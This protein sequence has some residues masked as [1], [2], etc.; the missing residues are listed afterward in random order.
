MA[1]GTYW[2]GV[3]GEVRF[4]PDETGVEITVNN[5]EWSK[6]RSN[7]LAEVTNAQS[8]GNSKYIASVNDQDGTFT[9]VWDSD[10]EPESVGLIEGALGVLKEY[11]GAS[12]SGKEQDVIIGKL[13]F[14][15]NT[16][17]GA[18][19]YTVTYK[20]NGPITDF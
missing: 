18:I 9:V 1:E 7:R 4:T 14:K 6:D 16:Q 3:G 12:G 17:N 15:V 19:M 20:G 5:T 13:S 11:L 8:G 2:S 10:A